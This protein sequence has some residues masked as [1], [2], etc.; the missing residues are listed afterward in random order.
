M[1][2]KD[3]R[4]FLDWIKDKYDVADIVMISPM[5]IDEFIDNNSDFLCSCEEL[6]TMFHEETE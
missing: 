6:I 3:R 2:L 1:C 5:D 4:A